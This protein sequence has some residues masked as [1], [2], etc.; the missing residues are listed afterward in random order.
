MSPVSLEH[1]SQ[2][3][4]IGGSGGSS[5]RI[6]PVTASRKVPVTSI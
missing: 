5:K 6:L 4:Q 3:I 1:T 2:G